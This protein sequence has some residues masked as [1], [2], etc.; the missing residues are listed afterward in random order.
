MGVSSGL[1]PSSMGRGR[2]GVAAVIASLLAASLQ[3]VRTDVRNRFGG[4]PSVHHA[5]DNARAPHGFNA[6]PPGYPAATLCAKPDWLDEE[7]D[8]SGQ[9]KVAWPD[10]AS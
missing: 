4:A 10:A 3:S 2:G 5:L 6:V 1:S 7:V 8:G 9:G